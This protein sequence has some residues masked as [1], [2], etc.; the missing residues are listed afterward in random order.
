MP[1]RVFFSFHFAKDFWRT[2]QVRN[3]NALE[4]QTICSSNDW[5]DVKKNGSAAVERWIEN[6][7]HGKSCV[8]V[9][10]GAETATRPWV[11]HEIKKGW[12]D[13]KGVLGIRIDRMLGT[14]GNSSTPGINPFQ[15]VSYGTGTLASV[16]PLKVPTGSNSKEVYAS[17][18]NNIEAWIEEAIRTRNN[19]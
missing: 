11:I 5:E 7:M 3:I 18:A 16:A 4:G 10:T 1:R 12:N 6:Q 8:V 19:Y 2:Q 14:D 17:I 15:Q 9:L 13:G